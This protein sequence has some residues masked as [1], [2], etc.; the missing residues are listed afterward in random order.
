[1]TPQ[2]KRKLSKIADVRYKFVSGFSGTIRRE[3][4]NRQI[5]DMKTESP[6][7][8]TGYAATANLHTIPARLISNT[9]AQDMQQPK[10]AR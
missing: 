6:P 10:Q 5:S 4:A 9:S 3:R 7:P 1:L 2:Y 8:H